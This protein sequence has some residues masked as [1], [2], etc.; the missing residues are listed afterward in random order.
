MAKKARKAWHGQLQWAQS[1]QLTPRRYNCG[2][3]GNSELSDRG[4]PTQDQKIGVWLC[5]ECTFPS[6][7]AYDDQCPGPTAGK[8]IA[9]LP[10][11][12]DNLYEEA[13]DCLTVSAFTG[14]VLLCRKLLMNVAVSQGAV[15][16]LSF[17]AY[18][19]YLLNA[20]LVPSNARQW[21][22]SIRKKGNDATH[23]IPQTNREDAVTILE[24]TD[25]L[26]R[27]TYELPQ[28]AS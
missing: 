12:I 10:P 9:H 22:D 23:E 19:D 16:N 15:V 21:L 11:E 28:R 24:F 8:L 2:H 5:P 7:L 20:H 17:Q 1:I 4:F 18:V 26:L 3:C 25:M 27:L 13:R 6:F 14:T